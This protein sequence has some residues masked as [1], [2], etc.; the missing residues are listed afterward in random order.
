V[1]ASWS[2]NLRAVGICAAI[3]VGASLG[4]L[5]PAAMAAPP[6]DL[7]ANRTNLGDELPV[8]L[9]ES[10]LEATRDGYTVV[11]TFA[12]GHSIWW[13]WQSPRTEWTTVS[14]CDSDFATVVGV[15]E[16]GEFGYLKPLSVGNSAEGPGCWGRESRYT[17]WAEAGHD[18]ELGGDGFGF[19]PPGGTPPTGEG[20]IALSIE[21]TAAPPNDAFAAATPIGG[22]YSEPGGNPFEPPNDD[23]HLY[24]SLDGYNWG[25][26][27]EPGEPQLA[28]GGG[29]S[30][31]Y[32]WTPPES[33]TVTLSICCQATPELVTLY[34]GDSLSGLTPIA[35][36]TTAMARPSAAVIGGAPYMI[37]VA[38]GADPVAARPRMGS[39]ALDLEMAVPRK[40]EGSPSSTGTTAAPAQAS[41]PGP[42]AFAA[43]AVPTIAHHSV[44]VE[45]RSA[46]FRF[47]SAT[48]GAT[49]RC[50][51]DAKPFRA[52]SSP[53]KITGV[54]PGK[55][56][57]E[58][59]AM[60]P[61]RPASAP[62]VAHFSVP[63]P[64]RRHH[65]TG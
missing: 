34:A 23:R 27:T 35:A 32:S 52:C 19:Y 8:H 42:H 26:T 15:F 54:E 51:L 18:Y 2:I 38:G 58:V 21:P 65:R 56:R 37:R 5:A 4:V 60:A 64:Q 17:F 33:G 62:A 7:Y 13:E 14:T 24:T 25:A 43:P 29:A 44:D 22:G 55:H 30:V 16:E 3:A 46:T 12:A 47:G 53:L 9:T 61:G 57:L 6:N 48:K 31:W 11:N 41:L 49:Y 28:P 10:N 50:R 36:G 1:G 63:A 20:T 59:E 45:A 39:F 40:V